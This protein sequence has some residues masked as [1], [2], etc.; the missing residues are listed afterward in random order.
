MRSS[1]AAITEAG[2]LGVVGQAHFLVVLILRSA[3]SVD[4]EGAQGKM[5]ALHVAL[6]FS[7]GVRVDEGLT[8][9]VTTGAFGGVTIPWDGRTILGRDLVDRFRY[10]IA[11]ARQR[12]TR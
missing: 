1:I 4:E 2:E 9:V 12:S 7:I 5:T 10:M 8:P 6:D 11:E 3:Q